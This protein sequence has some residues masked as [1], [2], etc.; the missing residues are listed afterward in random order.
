MN[1][2]DSYCS[3]STDYLAEQ[4]HCPRYTGAA[5][6]RKMVSDGEMCRLAIPTAMMKRLRSFAS[7][8]WVRYLLSRQIVAEEICSMEDV[9]RGAKVGL[10][11]ARG[12]FE[13]ANRLGFRR[14][15][16]G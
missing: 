1:L 5:N 2:T 6:L 16:N 4:L 15:F 14:R 3:H 13:I 12:P 8:L 9:D 10:R 7:V 11:W